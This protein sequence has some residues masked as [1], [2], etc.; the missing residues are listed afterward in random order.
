MRA[1]ALEEAVVDGVAGE[2]NTLWAADAVMMELLVVAEPGCRR[3]ETVV[4][5]GS[6]GFVEI[7]V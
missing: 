6:P 5:I 2:E 1:D 3:V 7:A 4:E